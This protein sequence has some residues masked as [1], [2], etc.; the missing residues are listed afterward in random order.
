[1]HNE[2]MAFVSDEKTADTVR[3]WADRQG[4]PADTVQIGGPELFTTLL[5]SDAPPKLV[6]I[7]FDNQEQPVQIAARIVSLCGSTV[8]VVAL[9][10]AND[11][12]LFRDMLS[13]GVSDYLVKPLTPELLTQTMMAATRGQNANGAGPA[14]DCKNIVVIGVRGGVGASTLATNTAWIIAH[15]MKK[16]CALLDLDLQYGTSA[17]AL[18]IEPGHGL[19]DVLSSPQRVD[20]LMIAGAMITEG[21]NFSILSAEESIEEVIH[22]DPNAIMAL[23]KEMRTGYQAV[24]IDLPRHMVATQKRLLATAHEIVLITEMSLVGIRDTLRLRST[25]KGLGSTARITQITT[26]IGPNR[27]AAVDEPTFT[28]GAQAKIDFT[29]PDDHK[30]LVTASNAGKMLG[31]VAPNASITKVLRDLAKHLVGDKET[32]GQQAKSSFGLL[33]SLFKSG[34]KEAPKA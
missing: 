30:T 1:M 26:K 18:D 24:V 33:G 13:A 2:F 25:L 29:V 8:R 4:F 21:E 12:P 22:I 15:E 17:L 3:T 9:G 6:L 16:K 28:K 11:V 14:K 32:K 5:E 20:S 27:P 7:D 23:L 19:R 31:A 10:T 34:G